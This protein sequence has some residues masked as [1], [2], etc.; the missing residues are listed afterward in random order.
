VTRSTDS[1]A[2]PDLDDSVR[3]I[4][5]LGKPTV[6][7]VLRAARLHGLV[8]IQPRCGVGSH[9]AM[10][11]LLE[12]LERD[13]RPDVL[14]LTIDSHTRL[15]DFDKAARVL[16]EAP[17]DLNGYPLVAHGWRKGREINASI[18]APIEVRHG[19]PRPFALFEASVAA[20][21][22]S[23]EG[24]GISYNLPYSKNVPL[25]ES[26]AA[27]RYVDA[28]C[29]ELARAGVI[30]DRE[31]FGTLTAVLVPPSI[32]LA[33]SVIE[34]LAAAREGV[35]CVSIAYPQGGCAVQ[36][37]AAL[38][39]IPVLAQRYVGTEVE[40]YPVLHEFMGVFPKS[41]VRADDLILYGAI[42]A[43]LGG[44]AKM[45]TKTHHEAYGIPTPQANVAGM[46]TARLANS[47]WLD[48]VALD[49]GAV[50][51]EQAWIEQEVAEILDPLLTG[52]D[53]HEG[54]VAAFADGRLDIPFSASKHARSAIIPRRDPSGAIR[55][56]DWGG[57]PF[58]TDVTDRH[59][60]QLE[61][62]HAADPQKFM[63]D[64]TADINYFV[65][66]RQEA[67]FDFVSSPLTI[68][69]GTSARPVLS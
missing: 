1:S 10:L 11:S 18:G 28:R 39:C 51:Q 40:V 63:K 31:V 61:H 7:E 50:A 45:I 65:E 29:G 35:R 44:A 53:L 17:G 49:D 54:V 16:R 36:D 4:Q 64:L 34:T 43:R 20:G 19:S 3:F 22:T 15:N 47:P 14:T 21:F 58:S 27:Y 42:V 23:F 41:R 59:T 2:L 66:A 69:G 37:V 13:A 60:R 5:S 9:E 62:C 30:V 32:S 68:A 57:L 55:Y 38:R 52:R 48:F 25:A 26:M 24:G 8:A 6:V 46:R 12:T 67:E 56:W 33:I